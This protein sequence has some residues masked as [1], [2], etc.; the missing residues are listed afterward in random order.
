M[1]RDER[2]RAQAIAWLLPKQ[3]RYMWNPIAGPT[4][5][6]WDLARNSSPL[7]GG[8]MVML[9]VALDFWNMSG[10]ALFADLFRLDDD[11]L[12]RV[13]G[14][15]ACSSSAD[16]ADVDKWIHERMVIEDAMA[17]TVGA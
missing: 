10:K 15:A 16:D 11:N 8:E 5:V 1:F 3:M 14:L 17:P 7:S 4:N 9:R 12:R 2:Q 6:A 13:C